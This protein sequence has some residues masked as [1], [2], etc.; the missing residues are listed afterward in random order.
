MTNAPIEND[1]P[2]RRSKPLH[3]QLPKHPAK[4]DVTEIVSPAGG[5]AFTG[6]EL[7]EHLEQFAALPNPPTVW[8]CGERAYA[9]LQYEMKATLYGRAAADSRADLKEVKYKG[10]TVRIFVNTEAHHKDEVRMIS[11]MAFD[12]AMALN[13]E[14]AE[15]IGPL[16]ERNA[17]GKVRVI[18]L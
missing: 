17:S 8:L 1:G 2:A 15:E 6:K 11:D 4:P 14:R 3:L 16:I 18:R 10:M 9:H 7:F 5:L 13:R 12:R